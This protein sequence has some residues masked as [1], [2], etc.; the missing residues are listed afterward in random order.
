MRDTHAASRAYLR[1]LLGPGNGKSMHGIVKRVRLED[2]PIEHF[3]RE[4]PWEYAAVQATWW[5]ASPGISGALGR[6]S[7]WTTWPWSRRAA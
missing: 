1:G 6:P 2:D 7:S 5:T 4:S 3:V